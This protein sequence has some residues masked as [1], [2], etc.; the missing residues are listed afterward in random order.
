MQDQDRKNYNALNV[1]SGK[2]TDFELDCMEVMRTADPDDTYENRRLDFC[3]FVILDLLK[4]SEESILKTLK[5]RIF[6]YCF[7]EKV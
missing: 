5:Q 4:C 2:L 7:P 6:H 3:L 1:I